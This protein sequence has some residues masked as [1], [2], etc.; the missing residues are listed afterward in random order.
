MG[1][2]RAWHD[3]P[4]R[5]DC[6]SL[7]H[8]MWHR[9]CAAA[10][11]ATADDGAPHNDGKGD[12][13][14]TRCGSRRPARDRAPCAPPRA[15]HRGRPHRAAGRIE[16]PARRAVPV[17]LSSLEPAVFHGRSSRA[18]GARR[19]RS[20]AACSRAS[21]RFASFPASSGRARSCSSPSG[22]SSAGCRAPRR[23]SSISIRA[24]SGRSPS[25][26]SGRCSTSDSTRIRPS[27]LMARVA[28]AA[29]FGGLT[30][31][32]GAERVAALLPQGALLLVLAVVGRRL[33]RRSLGAWP[34]C[35]TP[36]RA[37]PRCRTRPAPGP[38][39]GV[40]RC[41]GIWH[42][43]SPWRRWWRRLVDYLLKA[44]AVRYFGK[45]EP[46]VRFFGLFYAGTG[47]AAVLI[48]STIG[49]TA[50]V[51]LGL[52]DRSPVTR[53]SS[54][55]RRCSASWCRFRGG[56]CCRAVS[57]SLSATRSSAPGYELL[58]TPL[59][60]ATKRSAKS[61]VDV[62]CDCAGKG[63]G[64]GLILRARRAR[65]EAS[66]HGRQRGGR[67]GGRRRVRRRAAAAHGVRGR[68]RGRTAPPGRGARAGAAVF[69][70]RL[71]HRGGHGRARSGVASN[72]RLAGVEGKAAG[73]TP[74]DD[75][76][77]ADPV[78]AA[79]VELR[80]RDPGRIRAALRSCRT[81][82]CWSARSCRCWPRT[83]SSARWSP[84][85]MGFGAR[86]AG[87]MVCVLLDPA[88]P[89]VVRRRLPLALEVLSV[90]ARARRPPRQP[91]VADFRAAPPLRPRPDRADR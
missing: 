18:R 48:Q 87:E 25:R 76:R 11:C 49:R 69:H 73:T 31:G 90:A 10:W 62:A 65:P 33:R 2:E 60:E 68:A 89:D 63:A 20:R 44:E 34:G 57:T 70:G 74:V 38:T 83:S 15:P 54:A 56:A 75:A 50:L 35:A 14:L 79:I 7:C 24:C 45:G 3:G 81:I 64:A 72:G 9:T 40:S 59:A 43:S 55:R 12:W 26:R 5:K 13:S 91:R 66:V 29:T 82:R 1:L 47:V 27:R 23:C 53:S 21:G 36:A 88:A 52:G 61:I 17:V 78:V 46:L 58:Y 8:R 51:R 4:I 42:S 28:G 30:G 85:S 39:S 16:R 37:A 77:P 6:A 67:R 86:A 41:C 84:R 71:H 32:V 19:A 22:C 80:S